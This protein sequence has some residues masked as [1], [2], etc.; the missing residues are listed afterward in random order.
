MRTYDELS[1]AERL[2]QLPPVERDAVFAGYTQDDYASLDFD[3]IFWA[4]PEQIAPRGTWDNWLIRVGR[5]FG[6]ARTG[7]EWVRANMCGDTPLTGGRWRHVALIAETAADARDVMVGDGRMLSDSG[8]G[9]WPNGAIATL[10]NTW[11]LCAINGLAP[12][13]DFGTAEAKTVVQAKP[14]V[15]LVL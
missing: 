4:R 14:V 9:T 8:A 12:Y 10:Y 11:P 7:A 15:R 3:W 6:K 1:I 5:G 2:A 13:P